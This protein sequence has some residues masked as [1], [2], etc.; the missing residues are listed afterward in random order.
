MQIALSI[1]Y[2]SL[3][4]FQPRYMVCK[5]LHQFWRGLTN[6]GGI[7]ATSLEERWSRTFKAGDRREVFEGKALRHFRDIAA[8][9]LGRK[10]SMSVGS[11]PINAFFRKMGVEIN[12]LKYAHQVR[13]HRDH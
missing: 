6:P 1:D 11:F 7:L 8:I 3:Q 13:R 12:P 5:L 4:N 2:N 9:Q 10:F